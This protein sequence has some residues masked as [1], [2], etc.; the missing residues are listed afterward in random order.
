MRKQTKW[1]GRDRQCVAR[2]GVA[3]IGLAGQGLF[4]AASG[5]HRCPVRKAPRHCCAVQGRAWPVRARQGLQSV[6]GW[7]L[8]TYAF[9]VRSGTTVAD[10]FP[11]NTKAQ[12]SRAHAAVASDQKRRGNDMKTMAFSITGTAPLIM[13]SAQLV[14]PLDEITKQIKKITSKKTNKTEEDHQR[15]GDLEFV[16]SLYMHEEHGPIIPAANIERMLRDAGALTR[17]GTKVKMGIQM[18]EDYAP[19]EYDGPRDVEGL[20]KDKRF[21]L[22]RAVVVS[23]ARVMRER[24]R[25]PEWSLT[26]TVCYDPAVFNAEQIRDLVA[27]AG[28]YIGLGTWRPRHGRFEVSASK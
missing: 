9:P 18:L 19:L 21:R 13:Q 15:I 2:Q 26:F 8:E 16:G 3:R 12:A 24:P 11:Q 1:S 6:A 25:F 28:Q 5:L 23:K 20:L 14:D 17:L 10:G 22:R 7:R 4:S 27:S